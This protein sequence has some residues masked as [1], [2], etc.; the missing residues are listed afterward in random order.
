M[1]ITGLNMFKVS[2]NKHQM[3]ISLCFHLHQDDGVGECCRHHGGE[4]VLLYSEES[5][6]CEGSSSL[7]LVNLVQGYTHGLH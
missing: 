5:H 2:N 1:F 7:Q 6:P 4:G 3:I